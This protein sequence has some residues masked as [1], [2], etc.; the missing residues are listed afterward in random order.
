MRRDS[1][2]GFAALLELTRPRQWLRNLACFAGV[3]FGRRLTEPHAWRLAAGVVGVFLLASAAVYVFNDLCDVDRDRAHARKRSRP[4]ADGR[5]GW[6]VAAIFGAVLGAFALLGGW[7][8]GASVL[9]CVTL[10]LLINAAY[11]LALKQQP[12]LDVNCIAAGYVLRVLGGIYV[13][14]DVPTAWI[15]VCV[16]FLA[17]LVALAKRRSE[18]A[19]GAPD[20][21]VQRPVLQHYTAPL[22][23]ALVSEAATMASLSYALFAVSPDKNRSLIL[24]IP[25]VVY[26]LMHFKRQVI[27]EQA[28]EDPDDLFWKDRRLLATV[29]VWLTMFV[30]I[31]YG[32][33]HVF[34]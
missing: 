34:R 28:G 11:S 20:S 6:P 2:G 32:E 30:V 26:G 23:D 21:T 13:L 7:W 17:L 12:L 16:Y 19:H 14:G 5:I 3:V 22:L 8:L 27:V 10:Y 1:P 29:F 31:T 25:V 9:V 33:V 24:T 18:L 15:V 4:L